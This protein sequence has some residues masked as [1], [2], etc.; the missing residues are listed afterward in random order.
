MKHILR[1]PLDVETCQN[2]V[3]GDTVLLSGT[4]YTARDAAHA[5]MD[6]II[7]AGEKLPIEIDGAAIYYAGPTPAR[8]GE[9]IGSVGPT[10]SG[11]M[12][13]YTPKLLQLGLR[14]IIGKGLLSQD[15][16]Q[17]IKAANAVYFAAYGGAG[18]LI[19]ACV[20]S[21]RLICFEDLGSE[22]IRELE[23]EN[24]PLVVAVD[25]NGNNL[26]ETGPQA[27]IESLDGIGAN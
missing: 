5:R 26:Y 3:V 19:A 1:T 6:E 17:A 18:A 15:V 27:Y 9:V 13:A 4:I 20:K 23:I 12:D 10:T 8:P 11:R 22:A 7:N 25:A 14:C 24:L 2:L 16:V 21:V